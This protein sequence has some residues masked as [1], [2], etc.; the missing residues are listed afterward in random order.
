MSLLFQLQCLFTK[1]FYTH[2]THQPSLLIAS[3]V[4]PA[5]MFL[6]SQVTCKAK[7]LV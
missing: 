5:N 2:N 3:H 7:S 1:Q 6:V 4:T